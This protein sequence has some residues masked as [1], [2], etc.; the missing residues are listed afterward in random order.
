MGARVRGLLGSENLSFALFVLP[1]IA[2]LG[3]TSLYPLGYSLYL[4]LTNWSMGNMGRG[5]QW[6]GLANFAA[7]IREE[8]FR[9]SFLTSAKF[10][11]T[12]TLAEIAL[13]LLLAYFLVGE[14]RALRVVRTVFLLPMLIPGVVVGT[15][16]RMFLNV[17][18]GMANCLLAFLGLPQGSWFSSPSTALWSTVLVDVWYS[19][20]FVMITL[21]AGISSLPESP[22]KAAVVD[23]ASRAQVFRY[24]ILP[25]LRPVLFLVLMF[26]LIDSFFVLDHIY[27]TTYGGPGLSTNVVTFE[28][29]RS[30][31]KYFRLPVA[32]AGSWIMA[33]ISLF[34]AYLFGRLRVRLERR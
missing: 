13:G 20:P 3:F 27:T 4:S 28:L 19:T 9:D 5:A 32:A 23:G 10:A 11:V 34:I 21:V 31:L 15:M 29:Y 25:L 17:N 22:L 8:V 33:V 6:V 30:G 18:S 7:V 16:W 26:R 24:V 2:F 12:A 14:S 1:A